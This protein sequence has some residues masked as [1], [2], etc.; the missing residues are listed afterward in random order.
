MAEPIVFINGIFKR[1]RFA[2]VSIMDRGF[3][4]G[5]G[6]FETMRANRKKIY[7]LN[8]HLDRLYHSA[9]QI[10]LELPV[11][12][13]EL[14]SAIHETVDRNK[15]KESLVRLTLT[16]GEQEPGLKIDPETC[17]TLVIFVNSFVPLPKQFYSKGVRVSLFPAS[18]Y[19]TSGIATQVKSCNLLS[20]II[21]RKM[22]DRKDSLE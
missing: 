4:Y 11:T 19:K 15:F 12:R 5:D 8:L 3:C 7:W 10:F 6:I 17:P 13:K 9:K 22:A 1:L 18:A 2:N 20:Q 16:R 21:I 14:E